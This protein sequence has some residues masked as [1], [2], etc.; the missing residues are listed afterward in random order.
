MEHM[1]FVI[2]QF[3]LRN[4][5]VSGSA[6]YDEW[7]SWTRSRISI[8]RNY[9]LPSVLNQTCR[10]FRWLIFFDSSTPEEF[11][12]FIGFLS[13]HDLISVCYSDGMDD[14]YTGYIREVRKKAGPTTKWIITTRVDN[15]DSLHRDALLT[16]KENFIAKHRYL[17]SLASGYVLDV[18]EKKLSHYF[19][20]MSPF[21]S[22]IE[23]TGKEIEGIYSRGHT[24]WDNL[25]LFIV[26]ELWLEYFN[27]K[28]RVSRFIL[29]KPLWMQTVHGENVSNSF[30]RGFPVLRKRDLS[31]FSL[32]LITN[33]MT[34]GTITRYCHYVTWKRYM[35][36]LVI[37]FLINK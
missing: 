14:F 2:T 33:R 25:R 35:K 9:C 4:K 8:F 28:A 27:P 31:D 32:E 12:E 23:D 5:P 11:G 20:P 1:H 24:K 3:N 36:C 30:Y 16:I 34:F 18:N 29:K 21:L 17:I 37:K 13:S 22:L 26:R 6:A 10:D 19:Y 15:D 7:L